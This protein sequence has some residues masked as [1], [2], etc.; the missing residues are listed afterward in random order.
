[1]LWTH[2]ININTVYFKRAML[3]RHLSTIDRSR[4]F[5]NRCSAKIS[6]TTALLQLQALK[7]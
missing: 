7:P 6:R 2:I 5:C 1:M 4:S 3:P